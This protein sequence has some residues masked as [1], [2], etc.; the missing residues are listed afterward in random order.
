MRR[1]TGT[2]ALLLAFLLC[3]CSCQ[4]EKKTCEELLLAGL[5]YGIDGYI[6]N[7]YIFLK[8]ADEASTFFMSEK[9]KSLMYGQKFKDTLNATCDF[10]IYIS[11]R[12]PYEI[13]IFECYSQNDVDE[14]LRMCYERADEIKIGMRFSE[15]EGAS[16][17]IE[18]QAYKKY[19]IFSFTDSEERNAGTIEE[20]KAI[21]IK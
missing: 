3:F 20:M 16:K 6:D 8:S 21:L 18:I 11:S 17:A 14:I 2:F 5:D 4:K 7:G 19:V 1:P 13:A 15:W 10:A 12:T 9:T